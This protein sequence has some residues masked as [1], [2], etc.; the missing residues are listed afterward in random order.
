ME[1][2]DINLNR[3]EKDVLRCDRNTEF[4]RK[5]DNLE[6]LRRI[7]CTYIYRQIFLNQEIVQAKTRSFRHLKLDLDDG[8]VQGMCDLLAPVLVIFKDQGYN[9]ATFFCRSLGTFN[10]LI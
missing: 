4:Y 10:S 1:E 7:M 3:I 5:E 6:K 8:Y 2:F 9:C